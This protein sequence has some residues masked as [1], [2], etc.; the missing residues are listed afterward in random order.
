MQI[1]ACDRP[2]HINKDSHSQNRGQS[3]AKPVL[4]QSIYKEIVSFIHNTLKMEMTI[5]AKGQEVW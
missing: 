3:Q 2:L 4:S 1:K 5:D